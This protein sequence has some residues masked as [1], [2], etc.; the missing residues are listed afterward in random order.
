MENY[1]MTRE[2]ILIFKLRAN[3]QWKLWWKF[4]STMDSGIIRNCFGNHNHPL[5]VTNRKLIYKFI[6]S[7]WWSWL[8]IIIT[9]LI[10]PA[11]SWNL[12]LFN[13]FHL[14]QM[15]Y[16]KKHNTISE[17]KD[18]IHEVIHDLPLVQG[19]NGKLWMSVGPQGVVIWLMPL[20]VMFNKCQPLIN[21]FCIINV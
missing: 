2:L 9:A 17:L 7:S 10:W 1:L 3:S 4:T 8:I 20:F 5:R 11:V 12:T 21:L 14:K 19:R 16:A 18:E 15:V 13:D 6:G